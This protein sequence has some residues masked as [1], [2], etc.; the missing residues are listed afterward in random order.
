MVGDVSE[1]P[2]VAVCVLVPRGSAD[3]C[4]RELGVTRVLNCLWGRDE[5][6]EDLAWC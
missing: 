1:I 2:E 3:D 6:G 5:R 4:R